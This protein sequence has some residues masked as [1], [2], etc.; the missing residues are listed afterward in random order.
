MAPILHVAMAS[1]ALVIVKTTVELIYAS[2]QSPLANLPG[3]PSLSW[4]RGAYV[5]YQ[6]EE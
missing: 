6:L 5:R 3:P 1:L 4:L 2:I